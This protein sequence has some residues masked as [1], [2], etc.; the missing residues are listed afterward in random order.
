MNRYCK[1]FIS[2]DYR[3]KYKRNLLNILFKKKKE[4]KNNRSQRIKN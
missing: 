4:E 1:N 2:K 3:Y